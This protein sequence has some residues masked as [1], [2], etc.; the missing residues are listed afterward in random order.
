MSPLR[1]MIE[2]HIERM[3]ALLDALDGDA[4]MEASGDDEPSLAYAVCHPAIGW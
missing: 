4:D 1:H 2:D 3:I